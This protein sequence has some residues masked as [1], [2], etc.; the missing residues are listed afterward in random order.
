MREGLIRIAKGYPT[1]RLKSFEGNDLANFIR[2]VLPARVRSSIGTL[3]DNYRIKGSAGQSKWVDSP[4]I[5]VMD[6]LVTDSAQR[7]YYPVYLFTPKFD[8]VA[9]LLGQGTDSVRKEFGVAKAKPILKSRADVLRERVPEYKQWFDAGPFGVAGREKAGEEWNV[10]ATFGRVYEISKMPEDKVLAEDLKHMLGL[11]RLAILRGGYTLEEDENSD[12]E[13]APSDKVWKDGNLKLKVHER[14]ERRRNSSLAKEVK[15]KQGYICRGC[16]FNF[17]AV[18]GKAGEKYIDAH[19]LVPLA[20]LT[21]DGPVSRNP[22]TDFAVL[23][24]NCHRM[25]HKLGCPSLADFRNAVGTDYINALK[26][27]L[28]DQ[29]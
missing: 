19:H 29:T 6:P 14:L 9:L 28:N 15:R 16:G 7:G 21:E 25:I 13:E 3:S 18:Y 20:D 4:W 8:R 23:C 22:K 17:Y 24:A 5:A 26:S 1:A 11:Y 10:S 27:F 12:D 2:N